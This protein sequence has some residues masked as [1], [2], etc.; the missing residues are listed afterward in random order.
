MK[1]EIKKNQVAGT[2]DGWCA[3]CQLIL[4][5]TIDAMVGNKPTRVHCNTCESKHAYK[6][7]EPANAAPR[8][9]QS[10][11]GNGAKPVRLPAN[12]YKAL[13]KKSDTAVAKK[14]SPKDRYE[15]GDVLEHASFG[16]GFAT[17]VRGGT[18]IEVLFETGSKLLIQGWS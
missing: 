9:L 17:A 5:H 10:E 15:T 13:L 1:T 16:R 11:T 4:P 12:R 6:P 18:K 14:Y 7:S 2:I 8:Q 3:K